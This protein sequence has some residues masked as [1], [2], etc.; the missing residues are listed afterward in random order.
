ME[1]NPTP[2]EL[3]ASSPDATAEEPPFDIEEFVHALA[4]TARNEPTR[5]TGGSIDADALSQL[6]G[7]QGAGRRLSR[8]ERRAAKRALKRELKEK[9]AAAR[10]AQR[11]QR[12]AYRSVE[13]QLKE[14]DKELSSRLGDKRR[15]R[16]RSKT[17][18]DFIGYE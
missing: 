17:W 6:A 5:A 12:Q 18:N 7:A 16:E 9:K 10:Q 11:E 14:R 3:A 1:S 8:K 15:P 13:S 4:S 2:Q